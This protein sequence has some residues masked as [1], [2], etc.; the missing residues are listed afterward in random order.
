TAA[1]AAALEAR[2]VITRPFAGE[3]LRV[4][5]GTPE[6]DDVF[7]AALDDVRNA[8]LTSAAAGGAGA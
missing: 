6:E 4:S 3:G 8:E 1:T 2:A 5:V 7:L